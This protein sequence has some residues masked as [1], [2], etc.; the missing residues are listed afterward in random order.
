M[1]VS[2]AERARK[3]LERSDYTCVFCDNQR[4]LTSRLRGIA[5][6]L[7]RPDE[8]LRAMAVADRIVGRAAAMI[9]IHCGVES[10]FGEV[11]SRG[12]L[13]LLRK[14][15]V[16]V[17]YGTLTDTI[18]NREGTGP[19]PMEQAVATLTDPALASEILRRTLDALR[20]GQTAEK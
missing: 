9:F 11:M 14:H 2:N 16:Q 17:S 7:E 15:N 19:C 3:L 18:S 8:D 5:P 10:V 13:A 1:L 20:G 6:L 12:A 4:V